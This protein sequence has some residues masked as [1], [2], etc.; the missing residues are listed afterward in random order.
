[1][2]DIPGITTV[3]QTQVTDWR[4]FGVHVAMNADSQQQAEFLA[5]LSEA[6]V[7]MQVP[8]IADDV[9]KTNA[10]DTILDFLEHLRDSIGTRR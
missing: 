10:R 7:D 9:A 3:V 4:A 6:M 8:Y 1:M 5:G 2:S